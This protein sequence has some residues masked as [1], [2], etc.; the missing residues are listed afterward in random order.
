MGQTCFVNCTDFSL[1]KSGQKNMR[2]LTMWIV[3]MSCL[4]II[5]FDVSCN[6]YKE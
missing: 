2:F 4:M 6:T 1:P 3:M 5:E